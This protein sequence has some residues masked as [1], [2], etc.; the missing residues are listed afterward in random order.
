MTK[1]EAKQ[2]EDACLKIIEIMENGESAEYPS[3]S[4]LKNDKERYMLYL[5]VKYYLE[6][7]Y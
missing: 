2:M 1:E 5:S 7:R 6:N 4:D 3:Y